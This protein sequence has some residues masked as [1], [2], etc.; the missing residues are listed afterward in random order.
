MVLAVPKLEQPVFRDAPVPASRGRIQPHT[1][2]LPVVHAQQLLGEGAF[3]R[4]PGFVMT[5]R[6]Q[7]GRQPVVAHVQRMHPLAGRAAQGVQ[8]L[9]SPGLHMVQPMIRLGQDMSQPHH[10]HPAE[11]E[12]HPVAMGGKVLVQQG[13]SPPAVKLGHQ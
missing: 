1:L 10:R 4:L 5:Q 6:L 2:G 12:A 8:A 13:L 3:K 11:A 7:H 9:R